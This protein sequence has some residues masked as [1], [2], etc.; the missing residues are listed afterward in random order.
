MIILEDWKVDY[1]FLSRFISLPL[2]VLKIIR[3]RYSFSEIKYFSRNEFES[4]LK[5]MKIYPNVVL[6][7]LRNKVQ[8]FVNYNNE[9]TFNEIRRNL[10]SWEENEINIIGYF[11]KKFPPML[12]NIKKPPKLIF[13]KGEIKQ[14]DEIAV[15]MIGSRNPTQYGR[16]MAI[17]IA[18]RFAEL[19]FTVIS[20]FARGIDTISMKAALDYGGRAIGVI[21]SGILNLYPKENSILVDKL[22]NNGALISERFPEKSVNKRA[23]Q[24]RNRITSGLGL[25]NIFVEG[26]ENSGSLWQLKFGKE[27]GKFAIGVK[28][29]G[30]YEQAYVPNVVIKQEKGEVISKIEDV[31]Y[32]AEILLAEYNDRKK[33]VN[34]EIKKG[35]PLK[36]SNLF[37]FRS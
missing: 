17:K 7:D 12:K 29:I 33:K 22:V 11:E 1:I 27:Q 26:N 37:E 31:D 24:I 20:G 5:N 18:K 25:G 9:K 3:Q 8:N 6:R 32:I 35:K 16:E 2:S 19:G 14:Q 15:A 34:K 30:D 28:P 36:Q 23:L 10:E 13:I 4:I 21:A